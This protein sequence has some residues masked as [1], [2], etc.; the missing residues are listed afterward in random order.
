LKVRVVGSFEQF[1]QGFLD[2]HG[3]LD[4]L[5]DL[6]MEVNF[7]AESLDALPDVAGRPGLK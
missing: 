4:T 5:K 7:S 3:L 6:G 1:S 2:S